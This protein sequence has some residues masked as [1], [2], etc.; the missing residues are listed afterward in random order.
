MFMNDAQQATLGFVFN[1]SLAIN[2]RVYETAFSDL[3]FGRLVFVDTS[4][5][6]FAPGLVTFVSSSVGSANWYSG[7]AKD[8]AKA[9][10]TRDRVETRFHMASVG[11]SYNI[12]EVGQAQLMGMNLDAGKAL[13]ARRAYTEFMWNVTLT[14]D[15]TK[16]ILGLANQSVV[17]TGTAPADGTGSVTTWFD[18]SGN[19]TKTPTQIVRDINN[20][21]TGVYTGSLTVEM[22]DTILLPYSTISYLAATPM[23]STNSETIMSFI[24]RTNIYTQMTGQQLTVRGVL[25]LDTAGAGSTKRMVAYANREDVVKLHLPMPHRFLPVATADSVH[26][27]VPGIFR[28]GGVEVLRTGAFRYLDGI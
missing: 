10:I 20:V 12:E 28:T 26:F 27:D 8:I 18:G 13:A 24:M 1:Q 14:G 15:A 21:L 4:S 16:N 5:P 19:A 9:D 7:A 2:T 23:S 6:E 17:T 25:G 11:Y 22:A 3:D